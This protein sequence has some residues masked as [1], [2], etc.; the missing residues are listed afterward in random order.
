MGKKMNR[1]IILAGL[2]LFAPQWYYQWQMKQAK[3]GRGLTKVAS[4]EA[5]NE[6]ATHYQLLV[7]GNFPLFVRYYHAKESKAL[8]Y[9]IHGAMEHSGRYEKL[10]NTLVE[11]GYSVITNDHRGHGHSVNEHNPKGSM[12]TSVEIIEDMK[13]VLAFAQEKAGKQP[14]YLFGHSMGSMLARLLLK[15]CDGQIAKVVLTGVP[16]HN[17]MAKAGVFISNILSF[18]QG[19]SAYCKWLN[20]FPRDDRWIAAN[21][22]HMENIRK[23]HLGMGRF[24]NSGY[25][26]MYHLNDLLAYPDDFQTTNPQMPILIINGKEDVFIT[27]GKPGLNNTIQQLTKAGFQQVNYQIYP[28]MR[29]EVIHE[30]EGDKVIQA[31][32]DFY[33]Q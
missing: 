30:Q 3:Q 25:R 31:I 21:Q 6:V 4:E 15:E 18:Y 14:I 7:D 12:P 16:P 19:Q 1:M 26:T 11:A 9:I 8:I 28:G 23:D 20:M 24:N 10:A 13:S 2:S 17:P 27:G 5:V 32:L 22:D 29:H 33:E